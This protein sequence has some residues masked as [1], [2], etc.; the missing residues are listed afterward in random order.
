ML[1]LLSS[2]T[3]PYNTPPS[4]PSPYSHEV[5][6]SDSIISQIEI[7]VL[8]ESLSCVVT[9]VSATSLC[10]VESDRSRCSRVWTLVNNNPDRIDIVVEV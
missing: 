9:R 6:A 8:S 4:F 1:L 2:I 5:T 10:G 3:F 7:D